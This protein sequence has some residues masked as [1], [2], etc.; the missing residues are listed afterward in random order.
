MKKSCTGEAL[1]MLAGILKNSVREVDFVARYGGEEFVILLIETNKKN[2]QEQNRSFLIIYP[3]PEI[4]LPV[5][6]RMIL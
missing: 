5:P 6:G 1:K 2:G 4:Q 3:A